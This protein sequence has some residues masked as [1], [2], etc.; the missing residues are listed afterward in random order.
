MSAA[1]CASFRRKTLLKKITMR[2]EMAQYTRTSSA[3]FAMPKFTDCAPLLQHYGGFNH[4]IK[5]SS[6]NILGDQNESKTLNF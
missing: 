3:S 1:A 6:R 4:G 5:N 2:N